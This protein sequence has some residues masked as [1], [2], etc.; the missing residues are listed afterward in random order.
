MTGVKVEATEQKIARCTA[1]GHAAATA[2]ASQ[3]AKESTAPTAFDSTIHSKSI[4]ELQATIA[5]T[6]LDLLE[7]LKRLSVENKLFALFDC[8]D[9]DG[10]GK[11]FLTDIDNGLRRI[12]GHASFTKKVDIA[13][14]KLPML[15]ASGEN[16]TYNLLHMIYSV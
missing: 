1:V 14:D 15:D 2:L 16:D 10:Q 4:L 5:Q 12:N 7:E 11:I 13:A 8:L 6:K 9:R 3:K